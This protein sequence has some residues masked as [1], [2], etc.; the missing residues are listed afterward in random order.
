M[1][2]LTLQITRPNFEYI[3][4]GEQKTEHRDI[5]TS[6]AN[7][8]VIQ[9]EKPDG[10]VHVECVHYDAL[11]LIN[12]RRKDAPTLWVEVKSA[13]WMYYTDKDGK[14]LTYEE[15]GP[16]YL[17]AQVWYHLGRVLRTENVG[18]DFKFKYAGVE[19][20]D[21]GYDDRPLDE[22]DEKARADAEEDGQV[23]NPT[24]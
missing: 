15:N 3:M 19:P 18:P 10:T 14:P 11:R 16:R 24:M 7:R 9:T 12:G 6:N 5:Y 23:F 20:Y 8:Y 2:T 22:M 1:K 17:V 21:F 13:E 4:T